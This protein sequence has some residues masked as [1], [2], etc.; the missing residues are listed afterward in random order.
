MTKLGRNEACWCGSGKKAKRCH[1][2]TPPSPD[3]PE[4]ALSAGAKEMHDRIES[5][6]AHAPSL[7]AHVE[8][9]GSNNRVKGKQ[10]IGTLID[11]HLMATGVIGHAISRKSGVA[12][13][14]SKSA[15]E[16]LNLIASFIQGISLAETAICQGLYIQAAALLKQELETLAAVMEVRQDKRK[17]GNTPQVH[18]LP[19]NLKKLYGPLNSLAHVAK[20]DLLAGV[21]GIKPMGDLSPTSVIPVFNDAHARHLYASHVAMLV[22][23]A[24]EL[25]QLYR[26]LYAEGLSEEEFRVLVSACEVLQKEGFLSMQS[27][28]GK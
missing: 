28:I 17:D 7:L 18:G 13:A 16:R 20:G 27:E 10:I 12:G 3:Q 19:W 26:S 4:G 14:N 24:L 5:I 15:H 6:L 9:A 21:Y 11:A 23:A 22:I 2:T 1:G 25:D 8:E